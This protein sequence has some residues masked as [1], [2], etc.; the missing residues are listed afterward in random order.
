METEELEKKL[1]EFI[2]F[3]YKI[4]LKDS[5]DSYDDLFRTFL[6]N[7]KKSD[8]Y[9]SYS[10]FTLKVFDIID[11]ESIKYTFFDQD[12]GYVCVKSPHKDGNYFC[13]MN[14]ILCI[15]AEMEFKPLNEKILKQIFGKI[16]VLSFLNI[17]NSEIDCETSLEEGVTPLYLEECK[18]Y[19]LN[20][21]KYMKYARLLKVALKDAKYYETADYLPETEREF[22]SFLNSP[23]VYSMLIPYNFILESKFS[24]MKIMRGIITNGEVIYL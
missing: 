2:G 22:I 23:Y 14:E 18:K 24:E 8:T 15:A 1:K 9:N 4:F 12:E 11:K 21:K 16:R 19:F 13:S 17:W 5:N 3:K 6:K 20:H 10:L 7:N